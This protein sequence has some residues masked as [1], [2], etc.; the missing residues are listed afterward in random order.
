VVKEITITER[1]N[2]DYVSFGQY[3]SFP[4][5]LIELYNNSS[6]HNTCVNAIVDGIIGEGLTADPEFVLDIANSTGESW[7]DLLKK[8]ALDYKLYGGFSL[9]VI[10]SKGKNKSS[11][12]IPH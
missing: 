4:Q 10:W 11:R 9:E 5:E 2:K 7:N 8:V 6:I 1:K 3:N 12:G